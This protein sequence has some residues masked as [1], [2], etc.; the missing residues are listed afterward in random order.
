M[1]KKRYQIFLSST[2][3]D[4]EDERRRVM[5]AMLGM[6]CIPS[7][8]EF[9]PASDEETFDFIKTIIDESDYYILIL[10]GRYG[11]VSPD[12]ISYTEKEYDYAVSTGKPVLSF[13]IKDISQLTVSRLDNDPALRAKLQE[14]REKVLNAGRLA[15]FWTN[16]DQLASEVILTLTHAIKRYPQPGW[17]RGDNAA[18]EEILLTINK[19]REEN[20]RLKITSSSVPPKIPT[21]GLAGLEDDFTIDFSGQRYAGYDYKPMSISVKFGDILKRLGHR[22]RS[23]HP[24]N[25]KNDLES[26][27]LEISSCVNIRFDYRYVREII[28][29]FEILGIIEFKDIDGKSGYVLTEVGLKEYLS[30]IAV[31]A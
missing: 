4:L 18:S 8:M 6:D 14:F 10:A 17:I 24:I 20:E 13:V 5:M 12:G 22:Y 28:A 19:L 23:F 21:E 31:K 16:G 11:S 25:S 9:F 7:G 29:Q 3:S 26:L 1:Q 2:F 27:I 30:R 15:K